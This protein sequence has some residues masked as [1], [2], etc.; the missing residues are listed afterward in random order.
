MLFDLMQEHKLLFPDFERPQAY[1]QPQYKNVAQKDV[2]YTDDFGCVWKTTED[3]ITGTITKFPL[4]NLAD[5]ADY[6]APEADFCTGIG[7]IDW[8]LEKENVTR[9]KQSGTLIARGLRHGHT[10]L[11]LCD[12]CSY[13]NAILAMYDENENLY[14]IIDMVEQFN[15][16]LIKNYMSLSP[17]VFK[18]PEDLGMQSG[19]MLSPDMFEKFILPSYKK[20]TSL[21]KDKAIIHI[22]SDGDIRTLAH[23]LLD[24]D[25]QILNLQDNT[26]TIEWIEKNLKGRCCIELDIDRQFL[27]RNGTPKEI[28]SMIKYYVE[29]LSSKRGGLMF[30][31][32]LYGGIPYENIKALM[33]A[34]ENYMFL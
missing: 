12:L 23:F 8:N 9:D 14:S 10:F 31:Y 32:G 29:R 22:H 2:P 3:G 20:M 5:I 6:S 25:C 4:K 24:C 16:K 27:T 21:I 26:N 11:Q 28:D 15:C 19:P 30:V 34:L 7:K 33:D 1:Y 17:D 13:E 18:L